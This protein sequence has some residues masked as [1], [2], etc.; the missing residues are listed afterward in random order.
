M[1]ILEKNE[2]HILQLLPPMQPKVRDF[3]KRCA[4]K[5]LIVSIYCS[6]RSDAEQ[7][8]LYAQGRESLSVVNT[9]RKA[10]GMTLLPEG[11][12]KKLTNAKPGKSY[13][14]KRLAVDGVIMDGGKCVWD[15][16]D[17][18]W[19]VYGQCAKEAGLEWAGN[20]KRFKEYPHVQDV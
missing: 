2:H 5:G 19:H 18:R 17:P 4:A 13:H 16:A 8:A 20:W 1:N 3:L 7:K 9:L 11:I 6:Y 15:T 12:Y 14:A 10:A